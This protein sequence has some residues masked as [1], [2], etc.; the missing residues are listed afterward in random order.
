MNLY[1]F[2]LVRCEREMAETNGPLFVE[3]YNLA[4]A[5]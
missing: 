1:M 2:F 5:W 3:P 4:Q